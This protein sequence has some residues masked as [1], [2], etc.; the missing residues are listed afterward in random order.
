MKQLDG[1]GHTI[2]GLWFNRPNQNCGLISN[3]ENATVKNL[4]V[5]VASG[6]QCT[7]GDCSGIVVG[8]A[9]GCTL[10]SIKAEGTING[11]D[12]VGGIIGNAV[13]TSI[14]NATASE[15]SVKGENKVGGIAGV[16][17][18]NAT[19]CSFEGSVTAKDL[20]GGIAGEVA[21]NMSLSVS[22]GSV[23]TTDEVNGRAGGIA[24]TA[25]GNI[26]NCYSSV[27]TT[28]GL[29]AGGVVGYTYGEVK[30]CYSNGD[31]AATNFGAGIAGYLDGA[32]AAVNHCFAINNR[33]DV[34]DQ[35]GVAMR[36]IGGLKNGAAT[37]AATNFANKA[38]VV[39]V[40]NVTQTIYDDVLEGKGVQLATL[41]QQ[42]TYAAQGWDFNETW[43]IKEGKGFPY[44]QWVSVEEEPE[45]I[46]GDANGDG[47][48]RINDVVTT[49]NYILG[50]EPAGF[51]FAAAD[52]NQDGFVRINDVVLIANII[53]D[54]GNNAPA[55]VAAMPLSGNDYMAAQGVDIKAGETRFIDI[56]LN[57]DNAFSA[58][59]MDINLPDGLVLKGATLT[60]RADGH[61]LMVGRTVNGKATIAAFSTESNNIAGNNGAVIRLEVMATGNVNEDIKLDNIFAS[62]AKGELKQLEAVSVG[63]NAVTSINDITVNNGPVNVYNVAGQLIR[64]NVNASEATHNL[65]AGLYL[66]GGKKVVVK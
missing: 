49:S 8:K 6:K 50:D 20:S 53:L 35:T 41:M 42:A 39:S 47:F 15:L 4:T 56:E 57:N 24:G 51:V 34:S 9:T 32:N 25:S 63:V 19:Y 17:T 27:K 59:Q 40:N 44:L 46:T 2:S 3:I 33:I 26:V 62:T 22:T 60:G 30:N 36:V 18:G 28:G 52:V 12:Y 21:G 23:T 48:V 5:K 16:L 14:A 37:P 54:G 45:Y 10:D 55:K 66:V 1:N 43:S 31:I 61:N 13:T 58:L 64:R 65:P 38:M 7:G 29:Y 11:T